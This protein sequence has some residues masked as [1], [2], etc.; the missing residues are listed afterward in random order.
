MGNLL[1]QE[2]DEKFHDYPHI[3]NILLKLFKLTVEKCIPKT[4]SVFSR[5]QKG[6]ESI[7]GKISAL[8]LEVILRVGSKN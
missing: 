3:S 5:H 7:L 8:K 4:S 1:A 6:L 2:T